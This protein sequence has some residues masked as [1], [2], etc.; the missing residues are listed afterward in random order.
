MWWSDK[1]TRFLF[2]KKLHTH[3]LN[4]QFIFLHKRRTKSFY[5]NKKVGDKTFMSYFEV[6]LEK[7]QLYDYRMTIAK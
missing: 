7:F 4:V 6:G 1:E 5:K 3:K 2:G